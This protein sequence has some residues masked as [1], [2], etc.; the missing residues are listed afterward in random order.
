MKKGRRWDWKLSPVFFTILYFQIRGLQINEKITETQKNL[1]ES[2]KE[3]N[4]VMQEKIR[5]G[6]SQMQCSSKAHRENILKNLNSK[7]EEKKKQLEEALKMASGFIL[8]FI[9]G[10]L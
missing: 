9:F 5:N 1:S 6:L 8:N 10:N 4:L 7:L 3:S 2:A